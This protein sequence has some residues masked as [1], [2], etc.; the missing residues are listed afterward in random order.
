MS[1][2]PRGKR[3]GKRRACVHRGKETGED[4]HVSSGEKRWGKMSICPRGKGTSWG[5]L[6][7]NEHAR[8]TFSLASSSARMRCAADALP[9][10]P[11]MSCP[12]LSSDTHASYVPSSSVSEIS[13]LSPSLALMSLTF[14]LMSASLTP[15]DTIEG[16]SSSRNAMRASLRAVRCEDAQQRCVE[17]KKPQR[18]GR[19]TRSC[20]RRGGSGPCRA[21]LA[22]PG[23][24]NGALC[25]DRD[26]V[27]EDMEVIASGEAN[28]KGKKKVCVCVCAKLSKQWTCTAH[29]FCTAA[30]VDMDGGSHGQGRGYSF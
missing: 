29:L 15:L 5:R 26:L 2:C 25:N 16:T 11:L 21:T 17:L 13:N 12:A 3:D 23:L 30:R 22:S 7:H 20:A 18:S 8:R 28:V 4:E 9:A 27:A 6:V 10:P 24:V 14:F 19:M 1:M